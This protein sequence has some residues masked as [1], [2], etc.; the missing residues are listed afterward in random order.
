[1]KK[2][3]ISARNIN[4]RGILLK[5]WNKKCCCCLV[6]SVV[7]DSVR[8]HRLQPTRLHHPWDSPG[9]NTGV[10]CHFL[11]QCM[12]WKVKGKSLSHVL[13]LAT[14]WTAAYQAP[15]SVRF[16][17]QE[18][19]SGVPLPS[20]EIKNRLLNYLLI[21]FKLGSLIGQ[22]VRIC[23]KCR[24]LQFNSWVRKIPWK[25]DRLPLQYSWASLVAQL[26][27]NPIQSTKTRLGADW[28]SAHEL[29]IAKFW[30]KL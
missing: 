8:P 1:M 10:G 4:R 5:R 12:K 11:L 14:P 13:L 16:S 27:R 17:R 22:L 25:S 3:C 6:A 24:I 20:P 7:S 23:L 28:G 9:K 30:L 15:P 21:N 2:E 29:L 18:Y 19:W 26:V